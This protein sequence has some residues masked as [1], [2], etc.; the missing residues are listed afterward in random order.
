[1]LSLLKKWDSIFD[2]GHG[3]LG[4]DYYKSMAYGG[5]FRDKSNTPTDSFK[6][7]VPDLSKRNKIIEILLKEQNGEFSAKCKKCN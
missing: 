7:Q 1:M 5:L 4:E 3:N 2:D 6:S